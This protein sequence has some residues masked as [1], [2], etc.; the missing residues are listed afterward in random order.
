MCKMYRFPKCR[1]HVI[2]RMIKDI[3]V[4]YYRQNLSLAGGFFVFRFGLFVKEEEVV[5][6]FFTGEAC[7]LLNMN[8]DQIYCFK[9][10]SVVHCYTK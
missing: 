3:L 4:L 2:G 5:F 9:F 6:G 7:V 8:L 1:F 10:V